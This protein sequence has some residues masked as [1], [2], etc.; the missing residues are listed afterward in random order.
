MFLYVEV[1]GLCGSKVAYE[2]FYIGFYASCE[3]V[4]GAAL[5]VGVLEGFP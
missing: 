3:V 4:G 1:W 5:G 2:G